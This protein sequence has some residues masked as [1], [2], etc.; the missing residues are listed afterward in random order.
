MGRHLRLSRE[1]D[2]LPLSARRCTAAS[3]YTALPPPLACALESWRGRRWARQS[4]PA[5]PCECTCSRWLRG[6]ECGGR[7]SISWRR[8][9]V[10]A[11]GRGAPEAEQLKLPKTAA[12][13]CWGCVTVRVCRASI[14]VNAVKR[15]A[16][17][18]TDRF[19]FLYAIVT[20]YGI[21]IVIASGHAIRRRLGLA[22]PSAPPPGSLKRVTS[23]HLATTSE[24][25]PTCHRRHLSGEP[26]HST[27]RDK[28]AAAAAAAAAAAGRAASSTRR[29]TF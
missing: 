29:L 6:P 12:A 18:L 17:L 7:S 20:G 3:S 11:A 28:E 9:P 19:F 10:S 8:K 14:C 1:G 15:H 25:R 5:R 24:H 27:V 4:T 13:L 22:S 2:P 21:G 26:L 23:S 16:V